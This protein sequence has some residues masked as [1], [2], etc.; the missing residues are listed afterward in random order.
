[1]FI[2]EQPVYNMSYTGLPYKYI[3]CLR[4]HLLD[5]SNLIIEYFGYRPFSIKTNKKAAN[6]KKIISHGKVTENY[7]ILLII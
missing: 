3:F 1:M 5:V 7:Y 6:T 2:I 4:M